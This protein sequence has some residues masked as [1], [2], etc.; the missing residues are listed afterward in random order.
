MSIEKKL[1]NIIS[2][3]Q[4]PELEDYLKKGGDPNI[5]L[6]KQGGNSALHEASRQ[7]YFL[8]VEKLIEHNAD[9][10]IRNDFKLTPITLAFRNHHGKCVEILLRV[11]RELRSLENIWSQLSGA[12]TIWNTSN[13][14]MIKALI[15]ATPDLS[16]TRSNLQKNILYIC[17]E[18]MMYGSLKMM[19]YGGYV[20]SDEQLSRFDLNE[21]LD[22]KIIEWLKEYK[23]NAQSLQHYSRLAIRR[24]F[25]GNCNVVYGAE[26]LP[27]P[28]P[29]KLYVCIK[30]ED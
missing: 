12:K 10:D 17:H 20:F 7:G 1:L 15:K 29:T 19:V 2:R 3:N 13:D 24:S 28:R 5:R 6:M 22:K 8:C 21:E 14:T 26:R 18:R 27:L 25:H 23:R 9:P 11:N 16:K 4:V 30:D